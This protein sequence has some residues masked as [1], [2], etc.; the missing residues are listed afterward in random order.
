MISSGMNYCDWY[1][2]MA[3]FRIYHK[4]EAP[5]AANAAL[6]TLK[7]VL[8]QALKMLHPFMPFVTEE[9]YEALVPEEESLMMSSW[10]VYTEERVYREA[11]R[12]VGHM[13]EIVRGIR[14]IRAEMNVENSRKTKVY[15]VTEDAKLQ[16]GFGSLTDAVKPLMNAAEIFIAGEKPASF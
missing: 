16:E 8:G 6:W 3:K 4:E 14:N 13:K 10:P 1:I 15:I 9:I 7:T 2:E 11:E 5:E 12:V